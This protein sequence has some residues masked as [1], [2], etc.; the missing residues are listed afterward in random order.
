MSFGG[1]YSRIGTID[2]YWRRRVNFWHF[3]TMKVAGNDGN[4]DR[5][6]QRPDTGTLW[7]RPTPGK[8]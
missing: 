3:I 5:L 7:L 4:K 2:L 8:M 6:A 1:P